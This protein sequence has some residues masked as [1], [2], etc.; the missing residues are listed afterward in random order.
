MKCPLLM[1]NYLPDESPTEGKR[2]DCIKEEC[3]WWDNVLEDCCFR[4][5]AKASDRTE[6]VLTDIL[7][8][9]PQARQSY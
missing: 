2:T 6:R 9:L 8:K 1:Y 4:V 5:A 7:A 3:A